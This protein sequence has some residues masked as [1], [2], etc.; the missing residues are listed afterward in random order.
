MI[1]AWDRRVYGKLDAP[2]TP[3]PARSPR[4]CCSVQLEPGRTRRLRVG[5]SGRAETGQCLE[6][7]MGLI[8]DRSDSRARFLPRGWVDV[9]RDCDE[10]RAVR[11]ARFEYRSKDPRVTAIGHARETRYAR[12]R[13]ERASPA[14]PRRGFFPREEKSAASHRANRG[15]G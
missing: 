2:G 7:W 11:V 13:E 14:A 5:S 12:S 10:P 8:G 4:S 3:C 15:A 6:W 1:D 9:G